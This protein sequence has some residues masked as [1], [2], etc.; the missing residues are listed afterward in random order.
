LD[1]R[2]FCEAFALRLH[3]YLNRRR[4][5]GISPKAMSIRQ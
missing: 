3:P 1:K 4:G 2:R 5:F